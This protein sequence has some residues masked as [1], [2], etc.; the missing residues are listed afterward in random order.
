MIANNSVEYHLGLIGWPLSHSLSPKI[1][2]AALKVCNLA[3]EYRLFPIPLDME[4]EPALTALL[5]DLRSAVLQ[6]LNVTI[7]YKKVVIPYLDSINA[8]CT[9]DR[10]SEHNPDRE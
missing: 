6:G 3:G 9:C 8:C 10:R 1:H 5:K 4:G 2:Q 7:P